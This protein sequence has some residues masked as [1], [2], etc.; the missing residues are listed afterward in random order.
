MSKVKCQGQNKIFGHNWVL[1][2]VQ[3]SDLSHIVAY[4]KAN[5]FFTFKFKDEGQGQVKGKNNIFG[6]NF[7][8]IWRADL[9]LVSY[10][11]LWQGK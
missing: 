1:F 2:V 6:H 3:T 8:S 7:G 11:S 5:K 4:G 10:C 9:Q